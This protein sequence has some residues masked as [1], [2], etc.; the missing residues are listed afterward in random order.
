MDSL[1]ELNFHM[2]EKK[3]L[4]KRFMIGWALFT[5][6]KGMKNRLRSN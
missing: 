3:V 1:H 6:V 2:T 5:F 4:K